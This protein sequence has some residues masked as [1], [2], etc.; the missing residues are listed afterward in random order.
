MRPYTDPRLGPFG[1]APAL[2][3]HWHTRAAATPSAM[4]PH[5]LKLRKAAW[6]RGSRAVRVTAWNSRQG[7][8]RAAGGVK[9]GGGEAVALRASDGGPYG[10]S[11]RQ[12]EE[13]GP[14][15]TQWRRAGL[16]LDGSGPA[17]AVESVQCSTARALA[18]AFVG[19]PLWAGWV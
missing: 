12:G 13:Q 8:G 15:V 1:G 10:S 2:E 3:G 19:L 4:G 16:D 9:G 14:Y 5:W 17:R 7:C 18:P 11:C 6:G